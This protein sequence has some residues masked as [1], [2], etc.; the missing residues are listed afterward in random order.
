VPA[1]AKAK[2][3]SIIHR[4]ELYLPMSLIISVSGLRGIVGETLTPDV[5]VRFVGAFCADLDDGPILVTRD[6]RDSGEMLATSAVSAVQACGRDAIDAGVAATPT[7]GVLVKSLGAAGGVQISASHNPPPYNGIKLFGPDGRVLKADLGQRVLQRYEA[8]Q[9]GWVE[10][11]NV[12]ET[13]PCQDTTSEHMKLVLDT[14]DVERI[15]EREFQVLLDSNHGAGALLGR[16]LLN[17]LGCEVLCLGAEPNGQFAHPPEP[18]AANLESVQ[19]HVRGAEAVVGFCQD[20]DADRLAL[21]DET[22]RY[23]GEEYTLALCLDHVLKS[24]HGAVATN[25]ATS[26]MSQDVAVARGA[27]F[28]RAAVGEA[29]VVDCMLANKAVFGGEGNGGPIDPRVGLVRDSFVGMAQILDGL[30]AGDRTLSQWADSLPSYAIEKTKQPASDVASV[31]DTLE[32]HFA[33]ATAD[34][35]DGLR[36]DWPDKRWLL[37]RASNTEPIVRIIAEAAKSNDA[38]ALCEEAASVLNR[39]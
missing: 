18:T 30:A 14:V 32:A 36:L 26:R 2:A 23:I 7:A 6:G 39:A 28:A 29:N 33:D 21:I 3:L 17:E 38:A 5:V 34:R 11:K 25:C 22:G 10:H 20:P 37:I 24:R 4:K 19:E 1:H 8:G 12:G 27:E 35:T 16:E 9:G 15:R 31:L 13:R